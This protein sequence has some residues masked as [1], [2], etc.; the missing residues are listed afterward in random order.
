MAYVDGDDLRLEAWLRIARDAQERA[1][2]AD[3]NYRETPRWRLIRRHR[4]FKRWVTAVSF[5]DWTTRKLA[6]V[7]ERLNNPG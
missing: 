1:L 3:L 2:A 4:T 5:F 7:D 6:E